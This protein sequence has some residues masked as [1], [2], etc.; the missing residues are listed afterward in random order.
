MG[1]PEGKVTPSPASGSSLMAEAVPARTTASG[2][3]AEP[4]ALSHRRTYR[5][6]GLRFPAF[7]CRAGG[8]TDN[9]GGGRERG[10]RQ[11]P[12]GRVRNASV[13]CLPHFTPSPC[14]GPKAQ[15]AEHRSGKPSG[16][17]CSSVCPEPQSGK[18][19][20]FGKKG[21]AGVGSWGRG[22]E[23]VA[24]GGAVGGG[25]WGSEFQA[26]ASQAE[27]LR[28]QENRRVESQNHRE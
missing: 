20:G 19:R 12:W 24:T 28:S 10:P 1:L 5:D 27:T 3:R 26:S 25:P 16:G 6:R 7:S 11:P 17:L 13:I 21:G 22:F 15:T 18:R 9:P 4:P 8:E 14:A 23:S 2:P